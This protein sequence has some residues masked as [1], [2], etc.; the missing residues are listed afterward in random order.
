MSCMRK[1]Q[2][3]KTA[4]AEREMAGAE[5]EKDVLRCAVSGKYMLKTKAVCENQAAF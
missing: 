4:A 3:R 1:N 2:G 5:D